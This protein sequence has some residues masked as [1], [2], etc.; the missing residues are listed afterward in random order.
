MNDGLLAGC[1]GAGTVATDAPRTWGGGQSSTA[2]ARTMQWRLL[3]GLCQL[4]DDPGILE[5]EV[6]D[7]AWRLF[8]VDEDDRKRLLRAVWR[9]RH[10]PREYQNY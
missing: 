7:I 5:K 3:F 9:G 2:V 6:S 10:A 4:L 8:Q 1:K